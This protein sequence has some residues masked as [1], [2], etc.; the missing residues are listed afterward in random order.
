VAPISLPSKPAQPSG[1]TYAANLLW[2]FETFSRESYLARFGVQA[3]PFDPAKKVKTWFDSTSGLPSVVAYTVAVKPRDQSQ[4]A[5]ISMPWT[6][7][8]TVNLPGAYKYDSWVDTPTD[9][10][11]EITTPGGTSLVE[12][13][14]LQLSDAAD[15]RAVAAEL[16]GVVTR[17]DY[18][19]ASYRDKWFGETRRRWMVTVPATQQYPEYQ[20]FAG[21]L[22]RLRGGNA[23]GYWTRR[24]NGS[25]EWHTSPDPG[26][27][28]LAT[29]PAAWPVPIRALYPDEAAGGDTP[30]TNLPMITRA[31]AVTPLPNGRGSDSG[32]AALG[33]LDATKLA[34][35]VQ[36]AK[37]LGL[38]ALILMVL[39]TGARAEVT[40]A[41]TPQPMAVM[42]ALHV[43]TMGMWTCFLKNKDAAAGRTVRVADVYTAVLSIRPID[44]A[45]AI[46]VLSDRQAHSTASKVVK[47]L[48]LAAQGGGI[49]LGFLSKSNVAWATGLAIGGAALPQVITIATGEVPSTAPY[50]QSLLAAPVELA[51]G[52]DA[53]RTVYAAKQKDPAPVTVAIP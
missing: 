31:A 36:L 35:L 38:I 9:A 22:L 13:E 48:T 32:L 45:N 39:V 24:E 49:A 14:T 44:P 18:T 2:E 17:I 7:A 1:S 15:A 47:A 12:F 33:G 37:A 6:E 30:F 53:V 46:L 34:M 52:G 10:R 20:D 5:Q 28:A 19:N 50:T 16:G 3:P 41:C 23:P 25:F 40:V 11:L 4:I 27:A 26:I 42:N 21:E 29:Q 43:K 51:P 8:S